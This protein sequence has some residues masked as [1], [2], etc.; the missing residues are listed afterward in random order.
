M[1]ATDV[2]GYTYSADTYHPDCVL[3]ALRGRE[4]LLLDALPTLAAG[5]PSVE[6]RLDAVAAAIGFDR[7]DERSFDS[8]DFPKV[9]FASQ[10]ESDEACGGCGEALVLR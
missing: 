4:R 3:D 1:R 2:V 5:A 7:Y 10:V 8:D 9:V 6:D